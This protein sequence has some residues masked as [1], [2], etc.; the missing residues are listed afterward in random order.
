MTRP[1]VLLLGVLLAGCA[2][3]APAGSPQ[4]ECEQQAENDPRVAEIYQR[5]NGTYTMVGYPA[6]RELLMVKREAFVRCMRAKGLL[7][8]GGV[9]AVQPPL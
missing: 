6:H 8:P 2:K 4:T 5:S 9:Q 1:V 7:P 3:D